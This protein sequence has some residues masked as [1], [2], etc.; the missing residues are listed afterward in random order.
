MRPPSGPE[1]TVYRALGEQAEAWTPDRDAWIP[2][3]N[4]FRQGGFT[5]A[6]PVAAGAHTRSIVNST[7][8]SPSA[9]VITSGQPRPVVS[10]SM[11]E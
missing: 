9:V 2:S 1:F 11:L 7:K 10:S 5:P 4:R 8:H 3:G 6:P